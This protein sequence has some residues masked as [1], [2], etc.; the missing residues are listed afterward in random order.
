MPARGRSFL[1][2]LF[3]GSRQ[4]GPDFLNAGDLVLDALELGSEFTWDLAHRDLL[5]AKPVFTTAETSPYVAVFI[6][7]QPYTGVR[8]LVNT[9]G[10]DG[11]VRWAGCALNTRKILVDLRK[12]VAPEQRISMI[13]WAKGRLS[14]PM[15]A[16]EGKNHGSLLTA[17]ED[18]LADRIVSFLKVS[19]ETEYQAWREDAQK[20][21]APA[22]DKMKVDRK[23]RHDGWQQ[24]VFRV[25]D[26][27]DSPVP[28]YVVD[29]FKADPTGLEGDDL[30]AIQMNDF[31]L[32]VHA[33]GADKSFR[34]FHVRLPQGITTQGIGG[35]WLRLTASS[36]TELIAYQGYGTTAAT[37]TEVSPVLLDISAFAKG[38][39]SLFCPF[40]TTLVEI[41]I[42]REPLPFRGQSRLMAMQL[43]APDV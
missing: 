3:K 22:L 18:D 14:T 4:I 5:G 16:V 26:E 25:V 24:F 27:Y 29:L 9:P 6:G 1:G 7:N 8:E 15:F 10:M 43:F 32:D 19:S 35:L 20:W 28:D 36:G 21:S 31:D 41:H 39:D 38:P 11:T 12:D 37:M 13:P 2:A 42:H 40:T 30:D 34:C 23:G 33:Y 17:P